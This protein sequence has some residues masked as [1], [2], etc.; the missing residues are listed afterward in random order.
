MRNEPFHTHCFFYF[1]PNNQYNLTPPSTLNTLLTLLYYMPLSVI[2]A[3]GRE[4]TI[5]PSVSIV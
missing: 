3:T 4:R 5:L 2:Q 1:Y